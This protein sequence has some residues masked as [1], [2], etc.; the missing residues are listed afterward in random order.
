MWF[1]DAAK[2][3]PAKGGDAACVRGIGVRHHAGY[4]L[5]EEVLKDT[6]DEARSVASSNEFPLANERS[7]PRVPRGWSQ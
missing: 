2:T 5:P 6:A 4:S 7:M 1:S 3:G